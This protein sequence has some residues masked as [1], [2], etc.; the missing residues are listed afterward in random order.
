MS[1]RLC[2]TAASGGAGRSA[3]HTWGVVASVRSGTLTFMF[4]DVE[5]STSAWDRHGRQ[6][7]DAMARHDALLREILDA[8]HGSVFSHGGDGIAAVFARATDAVEAVCAAQRA[9]TVEPWPEP[10]DLRV[11]MGLHTGVSEL[12]DGNYFGSDVNRAARVMSLARGGQ[13]LASA[14]TA[15]LAS[16]GPWTIVDRG[17]HRLRGFEAVEQIFQ[18][19]AEGLRDVDAALS[20]EDTV[21]NLP[22]TTTALIG[23]TDMLSRVQL[24][25]APGTLVTLVGAGGV[26]KT[27][28][29]LAAAHAADGYRDGA[30]FVDL[31]AAA[32]DADV[33]AV[34]V[35]AL[36]LYAASVRVSAEEIARALAGQARLLVLD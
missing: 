9:L 13:V 7:N 17:R 14:A 1:V 11:R 4:T 15:V 31:T 5:R 30:W 8:H 18:I 32:A 21:G 19:V 26:G 28:L 36:G 6:M 22:R 29:A 35:A 24:V 25:L 34:T 10:I 16:G 12:R 23:R 27:R 33:M 2:A 3:S 20:S